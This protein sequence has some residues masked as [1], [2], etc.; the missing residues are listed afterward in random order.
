MYRLHPNGKRTVTI[1]P[2]SCVVKVSVGPVDII[3]K[4]KDGNV[5]GD[6]RRERIKKKKKLA[7]LAEKH[8]P[9]N[10]VVEAILNSYKTAVNDPNNELVHL[11]EIREA[12]S[13]NFGGDAATRSALG[14]SGNAWSR[15]GQLAN[16]R[17]LQQG[18]HRG[19]NVSALRDATEGE[20]KEA[21]LIARTLIEN[22]LEYL[23]RQS[24]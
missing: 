8:R 1:A 9:G 7:D 5:V 16:K 11:Y 2:E 17:P 3:V 15:L 22:Y 6:T 24:V 19:K 23:E 4:D 13:K 14:I 20:L 18:R 10:P 12:L 21:R